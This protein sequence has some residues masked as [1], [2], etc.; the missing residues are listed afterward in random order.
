MKIHCIASRVLWGQIGRIEQGFV[1]LG[2][3]ITS[4]IDDADLIYINNPPFTQAIKDKL[5]GKLKAIFIF[6]VL[7]IPKL[8]IPNYNVE[9]LKDQLLH[10]DAVTSISNFTKK[11]VN[12]YC[13]IESEV[14]Y[15][16]IN[17]IFPINSNFKQY[18]YLFL[19]R[20]MDPNKR[21]SL[22]IE[23]LNLLHVKENEIIV[24]GPEPIG[25]GDYYGV[26][27]EE[28]LNQIYNAV[29]FVFC[30]G[31]DEGLGLCSFEALASSHCIP[32]VAQDMTTQMEFFNNDD[33]VVLPTASHISNFISSFQ[34]QSD[35]REFVNYFHLKYNGFIQ[36]NLTDKA[37]AQKIINVYNNLTNKNY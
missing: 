21:T 33:F 32:I 6:N 3:E 7:D 13:N 20:C 14:I 8:H 11:C 2:H 28:M 29:D 1:E 16:P 25:I 36:K 37:V 10:A 23:A 18:K 34:S 12:K 4:Y 17:N 19:G 9:E 15:N 31:K 27:T 26:C 24:V 22:A 30:L 5:S 35:V